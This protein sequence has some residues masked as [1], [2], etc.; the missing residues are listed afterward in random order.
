[1]RKL[2][3]KANLTKKFKDPPFLWALAS[4]LLGSMAA[5]LMQPGGFRVTT[6][7]ACS[8][9]GDP[10]RG[11]RPQEPRKGKNK[12]PYTGGNRPRGERYLAMI[13]QPD[14]GLSCLHPSSGTSQC[15]R[16]TEILS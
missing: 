4:L 1:M 3:S 12:S 7:Q 9:D 14:P 10:Q 6:A 2:L 16:K 13:L 11:R 15:Q 5:I 8:I